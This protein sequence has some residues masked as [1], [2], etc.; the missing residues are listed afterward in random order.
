MGENGLNNDDI[1]IDLKVRMERIETMLEAQ[2]ELEL[3]RLTNI[4]TRLV[5]VESANTWLWR[6][7]MTA[8]ITAILGI[9][10]V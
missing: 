7:V 6:T 4:E 5:K 10:L 8:I 3:V 1:L 9:I 2:K